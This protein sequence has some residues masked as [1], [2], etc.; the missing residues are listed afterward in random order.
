MD[1][2]K[3]TLFIEDK[4]IQIE[5]NKTDLMKDIFQKFEKLL[6][7]D[8]KSTFYYYKGNKL[9]ITNH[10]KLENIIKDEYDKHIK[11]F[12][13][14]LKTIKNNYKTH[15]NKNMVNN[16]IICPKCM[17]ELNL[18]N[19][20][21]I[22]FE[23]YKITLNECNKGHKISDILL[24]E[25]IETQKNTIIED[26]NKANYKCNFHENEIF[27]SYCSKCK[28]DLCFICENNHEHK[29]NILSYNNIL[30]NNEEYINKLKKEMNEVRERLNKLIDEIENLKNILD[31]VKNN[32]EIYYYINALIINNYN[33]NKRNYWMLKNIKQINFGNIIE[34]IDKII[35]NVD[36]NKKF[37]DILTIFNKMNYKNE[38]RIQ[39]KNPKNYNKIR[40]FGE[41]FVKNNKK[42]CIMYSIKMNSKLY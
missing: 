17:N 36:T 21:L 39:Y 20:C 40:L 34:D 7:K 8:L 35:K 16:F 9:N 11:I 37:N 2:I 13:Y 31:T 10:L 27:C 12:G 41:T 3:I 26:G 5:N 19:E 33:I 23:E 18:K 4:K 14:N 38:I 30:F 32:L 15:L 6:K 29:N 22:N 25:F 42:N 28:K 24:S 1:K